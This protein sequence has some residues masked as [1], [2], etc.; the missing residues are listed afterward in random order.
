[1]ILVLINFNFEQLNHFLEFCPFPP[2][3]GGHIWFYHVSSIA[4]TKLSHSSLEVFA[5]TP[6][7]RWVWSQTSQ[8]SNVL[9]HLPLTMCL[10]FPFTTPQL[11]F[12]SPPSP[13]V[14]SH[15]LRDE[16]GLR[17]VQA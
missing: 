13:V 17:H 4:G 3:T 1:M 5:C 2:L 8:V 6:S 9:S 12:C 15:F 16:S 7:G 14:L 11:S 10:F